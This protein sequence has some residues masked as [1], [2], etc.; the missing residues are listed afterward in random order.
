MD[1]AESDRAHVCL[2]PP[3]RAALSAFS[4]GILLVLAATRRVGPFFR[5]RPS[6]SPRAPVSRI[7]NAP[8]KVCSKLVEGGANPL[9]GAGDDIPATFQRQ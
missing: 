1:A 4:W 2:S 5:C 3:K 7:G 9:F 8:R 6:L